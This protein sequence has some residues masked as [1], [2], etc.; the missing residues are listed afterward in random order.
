M[1]NQKS[2]ETKEQKELTC[3]FCGCE[4]SG[5]TVM[6]FD[7][8]VMCEHCYNRETRVC[9]ECGR[10]IWREDAEGD[11]DTDLCSR[12][13]DNYYTHCERCGCMIHIDNARYEDC[14]DDVPYCESCYERIQ[15]EERNIHDYGYKP[16]PVFYGS[17]DLFMGVEIEIDKGGEY[18]E[19]AEALLNIANR[20]GDMVYCK[21]DGSIDE[22]FEI[23]SHPMTLDYHINEMN[24]LDVFNKAIQL[25]YRSHQTQT[26]GLHIHCSRSAFGSNYEEQEEVIARIVFFVEKH[27]NELVKY[28][29]RTEASINRWASKYGIAENTKL[30][31]DK[32][33]KGTYGRYAAV[34][35]QN[36][37]TVEFRLFRGT[38]RYN[39]FIAT[40]QLVDQICKTAINLSDKELEGLSWS[41]FVLHINKSEKPEL[42][43]YLKSKRLYVNELSNENESENINE[44]EVM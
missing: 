31:Y 7:G 41:E 38:L 39:T 33:K 22:G 37:N 14:N 32:A 18:E 42:I 13:Y 15:R 26:C 1:E 20:S 9:D 3:E 36:Y 28:S 8:V 34:N 2:K 43:E 16:E 11:N 10:T 29:R 6:Q 12:C 30:T 27:W 5:E 25:G 23:V 19:N 24:W 4:L 35:L 40:L 44:S 21:H 17:G